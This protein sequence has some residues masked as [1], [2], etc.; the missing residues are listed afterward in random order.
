[1]SDSRGMFIS[2]EGI[3]GCGKS[4]V[5]RRL[6]AWLE[7]SHQPVVQT[8]EPG[9]TILGEDL[10]SLLLRQGD[11]PVP[12]AEAFLFEADRAQTYAEIIIPALQEGKI[13]VSDRNYYGTIAYQAFGR[14]L[15]LDLVDAMSRAAMRGYAPTL[16]FVLD[17][18]PVVALQRKHGQDNVDRFDDEGIAYQQRV[19]D[20]FLFAARRDTEHSHII[21]ASRSADEVFDAVHRV[22]THRLAAAASD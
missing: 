21:D 15:D 22:V 20:G 6:V 13:V 9:G 14:D 5:V 18:D 12:W 11:V 10:R 17:L 19:R 7:T 8:R 4:S 16:T 3:G 1:M 2:F